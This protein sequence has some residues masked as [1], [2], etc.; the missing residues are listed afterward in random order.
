[1]V[2]W[3]PLM[4]LIIFPSSLKCYE[5]KWPNKNT[6]QELESD[7]FGLS[8]SLIGSESVSWFFNDPKGYAPKILLVM[9]VHADFRSMSIGQCVCIWV[10]SGLVLVGLDLCSCLSFPR[11]GFRS[12]DYDNGKVMHFFIIFLHFMLFGCWEPWQK[13]RKFWDL[14]SICYLSWDSVILLSY[15][16]VPLVTH[17]ST[18]L[19]V[20]LVDW[21]DWSVRIGITQSWSVGL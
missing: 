8:L 6:S 17:Y 10:D 18:S 2:R 20:D 13:E 9:F 1:M 3:H 11:S 5:K 15:R 7:K 21:E 14:M 16:T 19:Q 12:L 4:D